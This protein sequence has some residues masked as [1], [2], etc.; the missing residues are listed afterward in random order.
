MKPIDIMWVGLG[1]GLGSVL[2]WWIGR[3]VG[4][5]YHGD[6]PLGT[7]LINVSGAFVIGYLSVLFGVDWHDRYGTA[8]QRRRSDRLTRRLHHLQQHAARRR[9]AGR[10]ERER[11]LP[12]PIC[13]CRSR[14]ACWPPGLGPSLARAQG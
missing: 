4:E 1:G 6:F 5:R 9:Q 8:S 11:R 14:S 7:F 13:C 12:R 2:R 10:K 3:V